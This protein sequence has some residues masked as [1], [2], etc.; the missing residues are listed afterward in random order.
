VAELLK[1]LYVEVAA[2]ELTLEERP[3][4]DSRVSLLTGVH[5]KEVSDCAARSRTRPRCLP[6]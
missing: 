6:R 1:S 3:Q 5:R 2:R 4:T